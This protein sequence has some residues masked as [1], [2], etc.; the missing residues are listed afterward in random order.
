MA[1]ANAPVVSHAFIGSMPEKPSVNSACPSPGDA[2]PYAA[3]T[4]ATASPSAPTTASPH[5][6]RS[7][8]ASAAL[9]IAAPS[10]SAIANDTTPRNVLLLVTWRRGGRCS[11]LNY[12]HSAR[13]LRHA[14]EVVELPSVLGLSGVSGGCVPSGA[15]PRSPGGRGPRPSPSGQSPRSPSGVPSGAPSCVE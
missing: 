7:V 13:H 15:S 6:P 8:L 9:L 1:S 2:A 14:S 11:R 12:R 5:C 3:S 4:A 10:P